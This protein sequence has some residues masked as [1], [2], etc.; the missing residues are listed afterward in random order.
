V[1][2]IIAGL[3]K[4]LFPGHQSEAQFVGGQVILAGQ[5]AAEGQGRPIDAGEDGLNRGLRAIDGRFVL[6][7]AAF[8]EGVDFVGDA[9]EFWAAIPGNWPMKA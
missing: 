6:Q 5:H 9:G 2:P 7:I 8:D 1:T 3:E 4:A